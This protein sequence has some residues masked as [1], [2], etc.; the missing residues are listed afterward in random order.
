MYRTACRSDDADL[1]AGL[2][3]NTMPSW[4]TVSLERD[5][6]YF[7]GENIFGESVTVMA[8]KDDASDEPVGSYTCVIAPVHIN[9][10]AQRAGYL[11]GLRVNHSY[12]Y[13]LRVLKN[14]FASVQELMPD[15]ASLAVWFTS[16]AKGNVTA[17]RL[18]E[19][20]LNGMPVYRR[21]GEL[22]TLAID[23]RQARRGNT[24]Q[25]M[26]SEDIPALTAFFNAQAAKY[27]F[28]PVLTEDWVRRLTGQY[29]LRTDDFRV[30]KN[31]VD[32]HACLAVWDQRRFKQAV[33]RDYHPVLGSLR[34][35]FN[36]WARVRGG[37]Q[38]PAPGT[39][40]ESVFIA[41]VAFDEE[42]DNV[43]VEA[44][45]EAMTE[46]RSRSARVGVL[47][48]STKHPLLKR[49]RNQ[50]KATAYRSCIDTVT[51]PGQ[52]EFNV[53]ERPP[54]PEVALL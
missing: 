33:V 24:L 39:R 29:G 37:V 3:D 9:G 28:S 46:V 5:P 54:Q 21:L 13:R 26:Q 23:I 11:G 43:A 35:L 45:R 7:D 32:I 20:G 18:L 41:F 51:W 19:G 14:G 25:R 50:L 15:S 53:D 12:R 10:C 44:I 30:L 42:A 31:G 16:I 36:C 4:V 38:L 40:L 1:R 8:R 2:R 52:V 49:L 48:I 17:T 6:S 34:R 47:G 27:Q 22:E